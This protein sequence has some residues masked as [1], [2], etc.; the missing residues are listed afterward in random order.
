MKRNLF[1]ELKEGFDSLAQARKGKITLKTHEI[2]AAESA[3]LTPAQ[4]R[5]IRAKFNMSQPVFAQHLHINVNSLKNWEQGR[6]AVSREA[7]TL[8]RLVQ[9]HPET[10]ELLEAI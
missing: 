8:L 6:A 5:A 7:S 2:S 10:L 4:I 3:L 9:K 1:E